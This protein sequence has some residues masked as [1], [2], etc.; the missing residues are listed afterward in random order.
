LS[1]GE[2]ED[3]VFPVGNPVDFVPT[4]QATDAVYVA[5]S[6]RMVA[7]VETLAREAAAR[8]YADPF[9]AQTEQATEH[10]LTRV[11]QWLTP[12]P[13]RPI[14]APHGRPLAPRLLRQAHV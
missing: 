6:P 4:L 3:S 12:P 8:C 1:R 9:H 10:L 11:K 13:G 2:G 5:G 14:A 7:A